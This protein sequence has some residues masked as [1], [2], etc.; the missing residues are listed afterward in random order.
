MIPAAAFG[1]VNGVKRMKTYNGIVELAI[2]PLAG[3]T[4]VEIVKQ[5]AAELQTMLAFMGASGKS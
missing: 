1:R 4:E 5:K 2:G 3:K